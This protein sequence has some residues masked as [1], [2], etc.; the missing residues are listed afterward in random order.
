MEVDNVL[1][2]V[3]ECSDI[4]LLEAKLTVRTNFFV[5]YHVNSPRIM[6]KIVD[7][8]QIFGW[9]AKLVKSN[10]QDKNAL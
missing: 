2:L 1:T 10:K 3:S 6:A 4:V 7:F 9:F 8:G 5:G